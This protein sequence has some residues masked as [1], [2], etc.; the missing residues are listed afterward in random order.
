MMKEEK[1]GSTPY[2]EATKNHMLTL[3]YAPDLVTLTR[4]DIA[5]LMKPEKK[6]DDR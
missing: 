2:A 3:T 4:K 1:G 6:E 5:K